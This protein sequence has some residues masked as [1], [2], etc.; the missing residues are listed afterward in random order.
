[1]PDRYEYLAHLI[2]GY[3]RQE[4]TAEEQVALDIWLAE[5][6]DNRK[7]LE[8]LEDT[9]HLQKKLQAFHEVDRDRLW[10]LTQ[11]K[12][13][14]GGIA[15]PK[16]R[17]RRISR[18]LPYAAAVLVAMVTVAWYFSRERSGDEHEVVNQRVADIPPGGN[19]ATLTLADGR[20]ITLDETRDGI[21][22]GSGEITY[23]DGNPLAEVEGKDEMTLLELSTPKGGTYQIT[24]PDGTKVWLNAASTMKYPPHF[25]GGERIVE[26]TGEAYFSV[27]K[28]A[29][30]PFKVVSA[31]QEVQVLGTEFNVSAYPDDPETKTTLVEGKVRLFLSG[32]RSGAAFGKDNYVELAPGEQGVVGGE[33]LSKTNVDTALYTAWKSGYFYF[34]RTP[35][36]EIMRQV[37][38]W[39]DI[40]V[41]YEGG[42]PLETLSGDIKRGVSLRGVLDIL[43]QSTINVSLDGRVLTV[44]K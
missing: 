34:K 41:V 2:A 21:V 19:R 36:D 1:M 28:D 13:A 35:L 16:Y 24:L 37:A 18:W 6:P 7:F 26:L 22:I 44:H 43:T 3:L 20:A 25:S 9:Q 11:A 32:E 17:A 38:R 39:Y 42:I 29:K 14:D 30:R 31:G 23:N 4:L 12:L 8:R 10:K 40:E 33:S 27:A 5:R 15:I